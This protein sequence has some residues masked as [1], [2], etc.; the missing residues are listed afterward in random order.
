VSGHI[1][2][3]DPSNNSVTRITGVA[4]AYGGLVAMGEDPSNKDLLFCDYINGRILRLASGSLGNSFPATLGETGL[5]ADL[6][7]LSPSPGMLPYEPNLAFWSDHAIKRRW[8]G[9][10][11]GIDKVTW[12]KDG[13]WTFPTGAVWVKHFDLELV[14]G[15]PATKRRIETR[16]LVKTET[17]A[18]GVSYRWNDA[19][20]EA[21]L[22][23]DEGVEYDIDIVENGVARTQRWGIP[24]RTSC[25]TCHTPQAGSM[26]SF[27]TRQ[28]NRVSSMNGF[29]GNQLTLLY[30]GGYF[31]NNPGSP[32][33]LPHHVRADDT[34]YPLE[35]RA[36]SYLAVNCAYCHRVDGTV[37]GANWDG[38]P[39]LT[40]AQTGMMNGAALNN[41]GNP[42]NKYVVPGDVAHSIIYNRIAV[43]NGFTRM[44]P[45]G[46]HELDQSAIAL[47]QQWI[48]SELPNRQS[49][50]QWRT[51]HFGPGSPPESAPGAD[52][53]GDTQTNEPEFL[54]GTD[55]LSGGDFLSPEIATDGTNISVGLN[56]PANRSVRVET[57]TD[58]VNW[59]LWD[60]PGN[61]G[62]TRPAGPMT[63]TG[64]A[65]GSPRFFRVHLEEN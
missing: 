25:L 42:A 43:Q 30:N 53:D 26:L 56:V 9:I 61:D 58:L 34:S 36:R 14:R 47:I 1:W 49:Y 54:A 5:F 55:P 35:T 12:S 27:T 60:V 7:D 41:G 50:D 64:P 37:A 17:N 6:S 39:Q 31:T 29:T 33:L 10:P 46:S 65:L 11:N 44:P 32:N 4:G 23:P 13:N 3:L 62:M 59:S 19:Q 2:R 24:S 48:T 22:V 40:L 15:N 57:S 18:Y 20:T 28:L 51:A 63:F 38:S 8:F 52:A 21:T 16:V 45:L